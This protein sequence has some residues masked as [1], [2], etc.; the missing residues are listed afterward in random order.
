MMLDFQLNTSMLTEMK[1][2]L[3]VNNNPFVYLWVRERERERVREVVYKT[4]KLTSLIV[5]S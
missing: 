1:T 3:L 2:R 5:V 4:L